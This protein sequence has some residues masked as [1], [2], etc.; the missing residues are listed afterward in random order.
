MTEILLIQPKL[1]MHASPPLGLA[2][3]AA[4]LEKNGITVKIVDLNQRRHKDNPIFRLNNILQEERPK[5]VGISCLTS[6][7]MEA[8]EIA[9]LVKKYNED[10]KVVMGGVH[11]SS[12][13]ELTLQDNNVDFVVM[14]EGELTT[15]DL[16]TNL[17][18]EENY[19]SVDGLGFKRRGKTIINKP[20]KL[21]EDLDSLPFPSWH[22]IPPS[23]YPPSPQ[24]FFLKK[25]PVAPIITSRGCPYACTFCA[26]NNFWRGRWR[27]RSPENV[28]SEIQMLIEQYGVKE[29]EILDDNFTLDRKRASKICDELIKSNFNV[30]WSCSNGIRA[31]R[32]DRELIRKMRKAGCHQVS[33]GIESTS[34][35]ILNRIQKN[36]TIGQIK[37]AIKISKEEGLTVGGFFIFGLPYETRNT[38]LKMIKLAKKLDLDWAQFHIFTPLPGSTEFLNWVRK[39]GIE[40]SNLDF[41]KFNILRGVI[42]GYETDVNLEE[43]RKLKNRAFFEFYLRPHILVNFLKRM[44]ISQLPW[45]F[46]RIFTQFIG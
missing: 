13:P 6:Y 11:P 14:G 38:A 35:K 16:F 28:I 9:E 42:S 34:Q 39:Q 45:L 19:E 43:L 18:T 1:E 40:E 12:L 4:V 5:L 33:F 2:Y 32:L 21:I 41:S 8:R 25:Y 27:A 20:R 30:S 24:G 31:D 10:I 26:S 17:K 44:K 3:I 29:F 15:L 22:L 23:E 36:I 37:R 46:K 7:Y